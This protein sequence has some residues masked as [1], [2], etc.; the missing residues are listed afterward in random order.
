MNSDMVVTF[1]GGSRVNA[2]Y[3]G[4]VIETDQPVYSGGD[5]SAPAPFDLFLASIAT[6]AGY[7]VL[8]FCKKRGISWEKI[9]LVLKKEIDPEKKRIIRLVLEVK[10]P[11]DFPDKYL[12]AVI[13][14]VDICSVKRYIIDPFLFDTRPIKEKASDFSGLKNR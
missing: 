3:K 7:Y 9:S 8:E 5:G 6:C 13:R 2:R 1:H 4:F 12:N 10:L 11:A 14:A